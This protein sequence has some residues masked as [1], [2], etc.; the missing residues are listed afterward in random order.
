MSVV[1]VREF[2]LNRVFLRKYMRIL[3]GH[4]KLPAIESTV[5]VL[6][7]RQYREVQLHLNKDYSLFYQGVRF[8][9]CGD[10]LEFYG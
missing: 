7:R 8:Y 9:F 1:R 10:H 3:S 4:W 5:S 6:E 2:V